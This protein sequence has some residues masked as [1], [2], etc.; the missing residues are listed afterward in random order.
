MPPHILD[1]AH[2]L[3]A[4][5]LGNPTGLLGAVIAHVLNNGNAPTI[6]A[7]V[8]ALELAGT[9]TIADV[10][11]GGGLG[12]ELLLK[13]TKGEVHGI[14]PSPGMISRARRSHPREVSAGRLHLHIGTMD[15]LPLATASLNAWISLNTIYFIA[16]L[17]PAFADLRR[18]LEPSGRGVLGV[19]D[20]DWLGRQPFAKH[21]FVVRA[22]DDVVRELADAG[23]DVEHRTTPASRSTGGGVPYN[24]LICRPG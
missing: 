17:E 19:A 14:E 21:G 10:G 1:V 16:D 18:V 20:P 6:T 2:R 11:F 4:R 9:E 8:A 3:V 5:Q 22:V 12:L 13:A 15:A 24:L 23:F 7:A